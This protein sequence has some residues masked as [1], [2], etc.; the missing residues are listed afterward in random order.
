MA[1]IKYSAVCPDGT[2]ITRQS[3]RTYVACVVGRASYENA[4]AQAQTPNPLDA[5]NWEFAGQMVA[6]GGIYKGERKSW[7]TD[8]QISKQLARYK[9][10]YEQYNSA[11]EAIAGSVAQAIARVEENKAKGFYD[12][13][14]LVGFCGRQDLAV[15]QTRDSRNARYYA[16]MVI[17]PVN[18]D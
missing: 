7:D 9:A 2:I 18:A 12:Q 1:K 17:L 10:I 13:W 5:K 14:S 3:A 4:L 11:E 16:E 6:W 15:A 8:E